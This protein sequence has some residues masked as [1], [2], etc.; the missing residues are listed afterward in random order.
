M[1][2][3]LFKSVPLLLS[4][5][6]FCAFPV[7][8]PGGFHWTEQANPMPEWVANQVI[9]ELNVRQYS[10]KGT[11]AAVEAD[12]DRI[13]DLGA[14]LIWLM[15]I[16]PVGEIE[17]KGTLGS[18]YSVQ[19]YFD[20]NPEFGTK[21]DFKSL[22]NAAH[23][24]GMRVILDWVANHS[25]WDNPLAQEQPGL[26]ETDAEGRFVPPHGT[27]W[28]DVIQFDIHNPELVKLHTEAMSYWVKNYGV[29]G[30]RCDVASALPVEFWNSV[31]AALR[32]IKPDI[33]M[34]AESDAG[35]L[36][37]ESFD[38]TYGW[39][40]MHQFNAIAQGR[41]AA[42]SIDSVLAETQLILPDGGREMLFTSNH[43]E[44]SWAG[45]VF[46]RLGGGVQVFAVLKMTLDGIPLIYNGQE[47]GL[48][49]RLE[50][51]EKDPIDWKPSPLTEFYK[52]L[53]G[54][55]RTHP[56]LRT[57]AGFVRI[58]STNNETVY[59]FL[60]NAGPDKAVLVV[61]NLAAG[62]SKVTLGHP[63]LKGIWTDL[64]TGEQVLLESTET[65]D[66]RS[67]GHRVLFR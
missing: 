29:D 32:E 52:K 62:D 47:I 11:F 7:E 9:Y 4:S 22:V 5:I 3:P 20:V 26:Y 13:E 48:D 57:G 10:E 1:K 53:T 64:F 56:A 25:A 23:S 8:T 42:S 12:L 36:Q 24:R 37:L 16:H 65:M 59:A 18:Y 15:P 54:L 67:W 51:F 27:D 63:F 49:K 43:D 40:L 14:H 45:T 38:A 2:K 34:L 6:P 61:A 21:E 50:F 46:E 28:T 41:A 66:L 39:K 30:F 33:F 31:T 19:N 58:P 44:N 60:R 55:K 35:D 17:R